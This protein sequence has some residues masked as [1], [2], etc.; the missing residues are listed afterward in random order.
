MTAFASVREIG[1]RVAE[2][3]YDDLYTGLWH[4]SATPTNA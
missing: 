4:H 2:P 3:T 1:I